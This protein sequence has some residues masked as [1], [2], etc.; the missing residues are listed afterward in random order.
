MTSEKI[1][2]FPNTWRTLSARV[3]SRYQNTVPREWQA[4]GDGP[5]R[6]WGYWGLERAEVAIELDPAHWAPLARTVRRWAAAQGVTRQVAAP[7]YRGG[8]P[9]PA[10]DRVH[11]L[12][13][14][15]LVR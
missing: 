9:R 6:F 7:R 3:S 12:A 2:A 8:R 10:G 4:P 14:A 11:G 5:G 1:G 15:Q 13:G